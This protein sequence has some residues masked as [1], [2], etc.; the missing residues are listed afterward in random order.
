MIYVV[1]QS[2]LIIIKA[3][4]LTPN[5]SKTA[6]WSLPYASEY[7]AVTPSSVISGDGPPV[8]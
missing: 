1:T 8:T 6:A 4:R 5:A 7:D 2:E 3:S